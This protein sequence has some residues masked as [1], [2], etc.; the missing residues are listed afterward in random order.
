VN[1]QGATAATYTLNPVSAGN[2]GTYRV[3]V[4]N[5]VTTLTSSNAVLTVF[6]DTE[7]PTLVSAVVQ[8]SGQTNAIDIAVDESVLAATANTNTIKVFR[9]G[10]F[11]AS[12]VSVTVSNVLVSGKTIRLRVGGD[13][14]R[15]FDNYYI[16]VNGLADSRGNLTPA[17]SVIPVSWRVRTNV[18]QMSAA[19]D[20][21]ALN[22]ALPPDLQGSIYSSNSWY[23]TNFVIDPMYWGRDSGIFWFDQD[24][25]TN[26]CAG[27]GLNPQSLGIYDYTSPTLFRT[28]FNLGTNFGTTGFLTGSLGLRSFVDDGFVVYLNGSPV[29]TNNIAAGGV[30]VTKD[31]RAATAINPQCVTNIEISVSNLMP[32]TN[33]LAVAVVSQ[34]GAD[35][36]IYFGLEIEGIFLRSGTVPANGPTNSLRLTATKQGN[37]ARLTWP[38][39]GPDQY[40]Y[41]FI[42]EEAS[43]LANPGRNTSWLSVSNQSNGVTVGGQPARFY[44]LRQGPNSGR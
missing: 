28:T 8:D 11:G 12:A 30:P 20:Y 10:T 19:W 44:R 25:T 14:W 5:P 33:W 26:I 31:T 7:G 41:G 4:S 1:L 37:G 27:D 24:A 2:A 6:A 15:F 21:Y 32:R 35:G 40:Y 18:I 22:W 36:D 16:L 13:N 3:I 38:N 43:A 39:T 29:Y 9:S 42:L 17:N 34:T 23:K